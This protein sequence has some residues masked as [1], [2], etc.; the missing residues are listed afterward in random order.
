MLL[1]VDSY[2]TV[3]GLYTEAIDLA[4]LGRLSIT[5]ASQVE[6]DCRGAW[7]ANLSLVGGPQIGPYPKRSEAVQAE[8]QWLEHTLFG[9]G[10]PPE[11]PITLF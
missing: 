8:V 10:S 3:Q 2:G 11:P 4:S 5:R 6:A 7:W 9:F 1:I